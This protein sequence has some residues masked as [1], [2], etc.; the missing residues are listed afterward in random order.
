[1]RKPLLE[2]RTGS[3]HVPHECRYGPIGVGSVSLVRVRWFWWVLAVAPALAG[4]VSLQLG[5]G[6]L[7]S[8]GMMLGAAVSLGLVAVLLLLRRPWSGRNGVSKWLA[9]I[10]GL[11]L[12]LVALVGLLL[13]LPE[14][15][16]ARGLFLDV[17]SHGPRAMVAFDGGFVL[18]GENADGGLVWLSEDGTSWSE[19]D[20]PVFDGVVL[21]DLL[22]TEDGLLAVGQGGDVAEAVVLS[23]ADGTRWQVEATFGN[24]DHGTAPHAFSRFGGTVVAIA[25]IYGNDVEFYLGTEAS[26]WTASAPTPVFDD[27]ESGRDIA[28]SENLC[29][30]VGYHSAIYRDEIDTNTGVAW[31]TT[32]GT[33]YQLV[34]HDFDSEQLAAIAWATPGFIAVGTTTTGQGV[35]WLSQDGESWTRLTG[36]FNEMT[37]T[38]ITASADSYTIFGHDPET[39]RLMV[40][41]STTGNEWNEETISDELAIGSQIRTFVDQDGIR[42][43]VGIASDTLDTVIWTSTNNQPW[44]HATTIHTP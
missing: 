2:R 25:S 13:G 29:V 20:D 5:V 17:D 6:D 11:M 9:P 40:W 10:P 30:G 36:S 12:G 35:A 37:I 43:A 41:T 8:S 32:T 23:S 28:C 4:F 38:G 44:Q 18:V 7:R 27:G 3:L 42:I 34:E 26:S 21:R 16:Q 14:F 22:I 19:I 15:L 31:V 33:S 1:M 39:G 24:S